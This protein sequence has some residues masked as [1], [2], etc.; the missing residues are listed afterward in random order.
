MLRQAFVRT[1]LGKFSD[2][3]DDVFSARALLWVAWRTPE[4][5]AAVVT[6]IRATENGR[7]CY[8]GA[9]GGKDSASWLHLMAA[10]EQYARDERCNKIRAVGRKGWLRVLPDFTSPMIVIEKDL[11]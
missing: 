10:I 5:V 7:V 9:C 11:S 8:L 4:I 2:M 6:Q 3:E 1:D